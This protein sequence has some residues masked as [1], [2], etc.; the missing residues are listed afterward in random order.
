MAVS[1]DPFAQS[2]IPRIGEAERGGWGTPRH[3]SAAGAGVDHGVAVGRGVGV[4]A[5]DMGGGICADGHGDVVPSAS[6]VS[7]NR[8]NRPDCPGEKSPLRG[9]T[10]TGHRLLREHELDRPSEQTNVVGRAG[11]RITPG[12]C[13]RPASTTTGADPLLARPPRLAGVFQRVWICV[14]TIATAKKP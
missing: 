11:G 13:P 1:R 2:V 9:T 3:R 14:T 12:A 10:V 6:D 4:D 8:R 5:H 7:S